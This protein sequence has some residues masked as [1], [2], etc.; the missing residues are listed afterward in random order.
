MYIQLYT[1][2][3]KFIG[4]V[5]TKIIYFQETILKVDIVQ[6][7]Q[8]CTIN[9]LIRYNSAKTIYLIYNKLII[10]YDTMKSDNY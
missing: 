2:I 5:Y 6:V 1:T 7:K 8:Y 3:K 10:L 9:F 4:I